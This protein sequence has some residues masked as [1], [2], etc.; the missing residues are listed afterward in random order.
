MMFNYSYHL[1]TIRAKSPYLNFGVAPMPQIKTATK[2]VNYA[3]YWGLAVSRNCQNHTEAWQFIVW[4]TEKENAQKY[5]EATNKPAA[6]RDLISWQKDDPDLG[7]FAEQALTARSWYQADNLAIETILADMIESIVLGEAT[8]K[9][10]IDKAA[11]Q[12]TLLM[13]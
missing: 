8:I 13:R 3:N 6:R 9:Q 7:V 2:D 10:A 11:N 5:L 1:S 12:V 4:L